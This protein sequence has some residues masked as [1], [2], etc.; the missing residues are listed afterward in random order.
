MKRQLF[1]GLMAMVVVSGTLFTSCK[2]SSNSASGKS[3][4]QLAFAMKADNSATVS[5]NAIATDAQTVSTK[6]DS[7]W[8]TGT[9]ATVNW[10]T[11]VANVSAFKL[12]AIKRGLEIEITSR[13]LQNINL[14]APVPSTISTMID[15]GTYTK[16][17]LRAIL[18]HSSDTSVMPLT[19]KGSYTTASGTVVP[20]A[21]YFNY[22]AILKV[23]A[24]N[25]T[26]T[27]TADLLTT[28]TLHLN[29]L[30]A[31]V[32]I[33]EMDNATRVNGTILINSSTNT[34][35]IQ[36]IRENLSRSCDGGDFEDHHGDDDHQGDE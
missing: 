24:K 29:A 31:G 25:V 5:A 21:V 18:E 33:S 14:F 9:H 36:Q 11:A 16:V 3:S 4:S 28:L 26:I 6:M 15:T 27:S 32:S 22:D 19:L 30:L 10:T 34:N 1:T 8:N 23:E 2:K 13:G 20:V 7:T 12:E 35:I 17:E